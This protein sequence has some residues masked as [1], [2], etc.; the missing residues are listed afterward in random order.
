MAFRIGSPLK[1]NK[2]IHEIRQD[3]E[4]GWD[5]HLT[6]GRKVTHSRKYG[7]GPLAL[8]K[9][10]DLSIEKL[11]LEGTNV[12]IEKEKI[13]FVL[14]P[15]PMPSYFSIAAA[16]GLDHHESTDVSKEL[17]VVKHIITRESTLLKLENLCR[18]ILKWEALQRTTTELENEVLNTMADM[19]DR[20]I[21]YID[22]LIAWRQSAADFDP[23]N[24]RIFYWEQ[25]NYTL[26]VTK[27][28]DFLADQPTLVEALAIPLD[29][30]KMNPLMLPNTLEE[31]DTWIDP[32]QR[33]SMD[34]N[35][36]TGGPVYERKLHIRNTERVLLTEL[37][38]A[39]HQETLPLWDT[40]GGGDPRGTATTPS[41]SQHPPPTSANSAPP[42]LT[43]VQHLDHLHMQQQQ[44]S[45]KES[46]HLNITINNTSN[47]QEFAEYTE[48]ERKDVEF[49]N[50][51]LLAQYQLNKISNKLGEDLISRSTNRMD[52]PRPEDERPPSP[53]I[54]HQGNPWQGN[55]TKL[56][57]FNSSKI[58]AEV[59]NA[60]SDTP[61]NTPTTHPLT[62]SIIPSD[63]PTNTLFDTLS[64][65][66][67]Q[68]KVLSRPS[69]SY[70]RPAASAGGARGQGLGTAPGQGLGPGSGPGTTPHFPP[71]NENTNP[72]SGVNPSSSAEGGNGPGTGQSRV[73]TPYGESGDD[74]GYG[75]DA[76]EVGDQSLDPFRRQD[77]NNNNNN[78]N[79]ATNND[80]DG[81][82]GVATNTRHPHEIH[83]AG[84]DFME[85]NDIDVTAENSS[86]ESVS[87]IGDPP[88]ASSCTCT[89][90]K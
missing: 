41:S 90:N 27:D 88:L 5:N 10:V 60:P 85:F 20:T 53:K 33:A 34:A 56:H 70:A 31:A 71:S 36:A 38:L 18:K 2:P 72:L 37:E 69:S 24:P 75:G 81:G 13:E 76:F 32:I 22:A 4:K 77:D 3:L 35:G 84:L 23:L 19:R 64:D 43:M 16:L 89:L 45:L 57:E 52:V 26:K 44:Q 79:N 39:F 58:S 7:Y 87:S 48:Q 61:L 50:W 59:T 42:Q 62:H 8:L 63:I 73:Y 49:L 30:I 86:I 29:K 21:E 28:M 74:G 6:V 67:I 55:P 25:R 80:V 14:Q 11:T 47:N 51:H 15:K 12:S 83:T 9:P 17:D 68:V 54:L 40:T 1:P 46:P 78:N 65:T 82:G 66:L